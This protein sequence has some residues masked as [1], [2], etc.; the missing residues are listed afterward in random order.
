MTNKKVDKVVDPTLTPVNP[1]KE[2]AGA[3]VVEEI[4]VEDKPQ[5]HLDE[6]IE[7]PKP[8]IKPVPGFNK[9]LSFNL[10]EKKARYISLSIFLLVLIMAV[11]GLVF[12]GYAMGDPIGLF[13]L[14]STLNGSSGDITNAQSLIDQINAGIPL[15]PT[16]AQAT[17]ISDSIKA[18]QGALSIDLSSYVTNSGIAVAG[19]AFGAFS[20]ITLILLCFRKYGFG[21]KKGTILIPVSLTMGLL[22]LILGIVGGSPYISDTYSNAATNYYSEV[23]AQLNGAIAGL[24]GDMTNPTGFA[25]DIEKLAAQIKHIQDATSGIIAGLA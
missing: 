13:M 14:G 5:E 1:L 9:K 24:K 15:G 11:V 2:D 6:L 22:A 25:K 19:V 21:T 17:T 12:G 16:A 8:E 23:Y 4:K 18:I 3:K 10:D 7:E 20:I